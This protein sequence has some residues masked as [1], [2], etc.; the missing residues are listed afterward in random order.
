MGDASQLR[1]RIEVPFYPVPSAIARIRGLS[2]SAKLLFGCIYSL[3]M[4][5]RHCVGTNASLAYRIGMSAKQV[6]RLLPELEAHKLIARQL[7]GPNHHR[8]L[9]EVIWK[10]KGIKMRDK[11]SR[12][13][14]KDK[15]SR[16]GKPTPNL[17]V[18][19]LPPTCPL[20]PTPNL[21]PSTVINK[22]SLLGSTDPREGLANKSGQTPTDP[23][24]PSS[25]PDQDEDPE[26]VA[27]AWRAFREQYAVSSKQAL[28]DALSPE[29]APVRDDPVIRAELARRR[30]REP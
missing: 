26:A 28:A 29:N 17:G 14:A 6:T 15:L 13:K 21:S 18:G 23:L 4:M 2:A 19:D 16:K 30:P 12:K 7:D 11:L 22:Q 1:Q 20:L 5:D 9:I 8:S 25:G 27:A 3:S 24:G 10:G